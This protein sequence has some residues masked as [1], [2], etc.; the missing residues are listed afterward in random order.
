VSSLLKLGA[1]TLGRNDSALGA[2]YRRLSARVGKSKAITATARKIAVL[3]YNLLK[4]GE[5]YVDPGATY[6]EE[7]HRARVVKNLTRRAEALGFKIAP[8]E[9]GVS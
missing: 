2:F 5:A 6:Y 4:N 1:V 9:I 8:A 3:V 7:W